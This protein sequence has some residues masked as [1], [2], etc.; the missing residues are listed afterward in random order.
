M[1]DPT[2]QDPSA[3]PTPDP[4]ADPAAEPQVV[5]NEGLPE[6]ITTHAKLAG[7]DSVESL[8]KALIDSPDAPQIPNPEDYGYGEDQKTYAEFAHKTGLTKEQADNVIEFD[9]AR[10]EAIDAEYVKGLDELKEGEWK[11]SFDSN[12]ELTRAVIKQYDTDGELL[13]QLTKSRE[14][15]NPLVVKFLHAIGKDLLAEDKL[16]LGHQNANTPKSHAQK[17][18]GNK[19]S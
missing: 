19:E 14:G 2:P 10:I 8:A 12:I 15:N 9:K 17:L 1:T 4:A 7:I 6:D 18:Y 16:V 13:K 3:E 5:W 11:E